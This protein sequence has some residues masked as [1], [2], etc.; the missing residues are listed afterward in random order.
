MALRGPQQV[1]PGASFFTTLQISQTSDWFYWS[2]FGI[3]VLGPVTRWTACPGKYFDRMRKC[4]PVTTEAG[5]WCG[6]HSGTGYSPP[7]YQ[8]QGRCTLKHLTAPLEVWYG[9]PHTRHTDWFQWFSTIQTTHRWMLWR[10]CYTGKD[11]NTN[12]CGL[13]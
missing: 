8:M 9:L 12:C 7:A 5:A 3:S 11:V 1:L 2:R 4:V 13:L 10:L 6:L